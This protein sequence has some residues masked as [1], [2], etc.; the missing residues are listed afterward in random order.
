MIKQLSLRLNLTIS[1]TG[2]L[3]TKMAAQSCQIVLIGAP[4]SMA[5]MFDIKM[6]FWARIR[7]SL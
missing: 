5:T 4:T 7:V 3:T 2:R 1:K 6:V